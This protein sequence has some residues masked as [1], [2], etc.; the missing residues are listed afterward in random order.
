MAFV[1]CHDCCWRRQ[2]AI[3]RRCRQLTGE[4]F[5]CSLLACAVIL[6][7]VSCD[8][9]PNAAD[10]RICFLFGNFTAWHTTQSPW[11]QAYTGPDP[12]RLRRPRS[13]AS[14]SQSSW[15]TCSESSS[16]VFFVLFHGRAR[17][18]VDVS[19]AGNRGRGGMTDSVAGIRR[20]RTVAGRRETPHLPPDRDFYGQTL[21][22]SNQ[23]E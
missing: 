5:E 10:V 3:P 2:T 7:L 16:L 18:C 22:K 23:S 11:N 12:V 8:R 13:A 17:R 20:R 4:V 21:N 1:S 6:H 9:V 19:Y 15:R 14:R